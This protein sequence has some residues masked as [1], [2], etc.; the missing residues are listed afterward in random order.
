MS[1]MKNYSSTSSGLSA[2]I[3]RT[4]CTFLRSG[5]SIGIII[6]RLTQL[7]RFVAISSTLAEENRLEGHSHRRVADTTRSVLQNRSS[8]QLLHKLVLDLLGWF[9]CTLLYRDHLIQSFCQIRIPR[10]V[11]FLTYLGQSP[12]IVGSLKHLHFVLRRRNQ[13]EAIPKR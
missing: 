3:F 10:Y 13:T 1:C 12:F 5:F 9:G 6:T 8:N 4:L 7:L 2:S 11:F